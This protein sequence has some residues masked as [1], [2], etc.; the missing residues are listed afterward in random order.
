MRQQ[1]SARLTPDK[2]LPIDFQAEMFAPN[3]SLGYNAITD[4]LTISEGADTDRQSVTATSSNGGFSWRRSVAAWR[5][6]Q[7]GTTRRRDRPA[8]VNGI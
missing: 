5:R 6:W 2:K 1:P 4:L 7:S 8:R 3:G